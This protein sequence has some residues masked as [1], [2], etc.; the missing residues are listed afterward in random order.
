[1]ARIRNAVIADIE[2]CEPLEHSLFFKELSEEGQL[3]R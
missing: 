1:V 3:L 2:N